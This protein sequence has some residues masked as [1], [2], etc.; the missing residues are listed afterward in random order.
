MTGGYTELSGLRRRAAHDSANWLAR[1]DNDVTCGDDHSPDGDGGT[2]GTG[3]VRLLRPA[4][5]VRG[6]YPLMAVMITYTAGGIALLA[7]S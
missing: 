2:D 6:Q 3:S 5:A 4:A 7:G 1:F